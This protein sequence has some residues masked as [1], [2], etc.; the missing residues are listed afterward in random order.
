MHVHHI[1]PLK[2]IEA[3]FRAVYGL[4][5][6]VPIAGQLVPLWKEFHKKLL[7]TQT[8]TGDDHV[9]FHNTYEFYRMEIKDGIR[10]WAEKA[11]LLNSGEQYVWLS[12]RE[13]DRGHRDAYGKVIQINSN[14]TFSLI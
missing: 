8:F 9:K 4:R 10:Y 14:G 5:S 3:K 6:D 7:L 12:K 2:L 11:T 1:I 13:D